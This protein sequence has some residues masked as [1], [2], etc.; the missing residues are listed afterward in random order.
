MRGSCDDRKSEVSSVFVFDDDVDDDVDDDDDDVQR[1]TTNTILTTTTTTKFVFSCFRLCFLLLKRRRTEKDKELALQTKVV[2]NT[3]AHSRVPFLYLKMS[4]D[5]GFERKRWKR[6]RTNHS[7]G[8]GRN[9][10]RHRQTT[11][12]ISRKRR[13]RWIVF[14]VGFI[15]SRS[16]DS[17]HGV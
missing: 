4:G 1:T 10:N 15:Q 11:R 16:S 14:P 7:S 5:R 9:V 17:A 2:T 3:H 13:S 6:R 8:F 12:G